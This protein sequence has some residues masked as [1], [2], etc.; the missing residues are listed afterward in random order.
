[1]AQTTRKMPTRR[2]RWRLVMISEN[3]ITNQ[4]RNDERHEKRKRED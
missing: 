2:S 4:E 1:M 3:N